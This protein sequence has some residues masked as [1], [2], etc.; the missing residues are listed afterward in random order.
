MT[1]QFPEN[2]SDYSLLEKVVDF[3]ERRLHDLHYGSTDLR[4]LTLVYDYLKLIRD[5]KKSPMAAR[6]ERFRFIKISGKRYVLTNT[7][8]EFLDKFKRDDSVKDY[9]LVVYFLYKNIILERGIKNNEI[10]HNIDF[11]LDKVKD[12]N[13]ENLHQIRFLQQ[14]FNS[15]TTI[16]NFVKLSGEE[17]KEFEKQFE[18]LRE[19]FEKTYNLIHSKL[20]KITKK[21]EKIQTIPYIKRNFNFHQNGKWENVLDFISDGGFQKDAWVKIQDT[22][23]AHILLKTIQKM[24]DEGY[25]K[26]WKLDELYSEFQNN[27]S[28]DSFKSVL[29]LESDI[30]INPDGTYCLLA[31]AILLEEAE[32]EVER[33]L[34]E[35]EIKIPEEKID[36]IIKK[37]FKEYSKSTDIKRVR[38]SGERTPRDIK[39][40]LEV[41]RLYNYSCQICGTQ[42][43]KAGWSPN[44][45]RKEEFKFLYAETGHI[46]QVGKSVENDV[47]W[48]MLCL[49]PN[50]HK[51]LDYGAYKIIFDR[52]GKAIRVKDII[53]KKDL[54]ITLKHDVIKID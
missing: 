20:E 41:R 12:F 36:N 35:I 2:P 47:P 24:R 52:N 40:S 9:L 25:E 38:I 16:N 17:K 46:K 1:N 3:S 4:N 32:K 33:E 15:E 39:L 22:I 6:L 19:E 26:N 48:N 23:K 11:I 10:F 14:I 21:G 43:K 13:I 44:M 34:E 31:N 45:K 42:I 7:A 30:Q 50:C 29:Q 18:N 8:N 28:K 54:S 27:L 49:C 51:K 53:E 37:Q 5:G